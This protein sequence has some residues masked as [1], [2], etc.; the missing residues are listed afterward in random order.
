MNRHPE[1]FERFHDVARWHRVGRPLFMLLFLALIAVAVWSVLRL[2]RT[3]RGTSAATAHANPS[4]APV[5][6]QWTSPAAPVAGPVGAV[7]GD[8]ALEQARLRYATGQLARA[9]YLQIV[10]DLGGPVPPDEPVAQ[11]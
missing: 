8:P 6:T 1:H 5:A 7:T 4:V 9:D 11:S 3:T 10:R 2:V